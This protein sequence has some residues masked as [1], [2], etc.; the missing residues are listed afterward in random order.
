MSSRTGLCGMAPSLIIPSR[1]CDTD[2]LCLLLGP[3]LFGGDIAL[4]HDP[5]TH[6]LRPVRVDWLGRAA[7]GGLS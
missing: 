7:G 1:A 6:D 2:W 3:T 4:L 5:E